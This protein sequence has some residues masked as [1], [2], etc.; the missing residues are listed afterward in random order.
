MSGLP[1]IIF[2]QDSVKAFVV[3]GRPT[4]YRLYADH[5]CAEL[6]YV[7][8]SIKARQRLYAHLLD[9]DKRRAQVVT[10]E[11]CRNTTAMAAAEADAIAK[12]SPPLNRRESG[13]HSAWKSQNRRR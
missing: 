4:V 3:D 8:A 5:E 9:A 1:A 6:V 2:N 12:E 11:F 13:R 10:L 7:G